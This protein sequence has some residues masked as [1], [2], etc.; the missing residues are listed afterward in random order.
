MPL[1]LVGRKGSR[2]SAAVTIAGAAS[3]NA[4]V[5]TSEPTMMTSLTSVTDR[6]YRVTG[7]VEMVVRLRRLHRK[8]SLT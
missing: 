7:A 5:R 4:G 8:S 1:G 3:P 6:T 2:P